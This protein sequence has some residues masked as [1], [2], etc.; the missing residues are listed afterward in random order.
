MGDRRLGRRARRAIVYVCFFALVGLV[1]LVAS[2]N[3]CWVERHAGGVRPVGPSYAVELPVTPPPP[4]VRVKTGYDGPGQTVR[5]EYDGFA[6]VACARELNAMPPNAC[7]HPTGVVFR[8]ARLGSWVTSF[9]VEPGPMDARASRA[10]VA[11][12]DAA[13]LETWPSWLSWYAEG[14]GA[15][16]LR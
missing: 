4:A 14:T 13:D 1:F 7:E 16:S 11:F 10:T 8:E 12:Y 6:I 2:P 5:F 9:S 3:C 15:Q